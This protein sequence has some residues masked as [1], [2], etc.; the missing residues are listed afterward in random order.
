MERARRIAL[1]RYGVIQ[2]V[3]D[4]GLSTAERGRLVRALAERTY[5]G[6][7]GEPVRVSRNTIDRWKRDYRTGGFDA[8]VPQPPNVHP[9]TPVEVLQ[10]AEALKRENPART[11]RQVQRIL[12][13]TSGWAPSDRTLQRLFERLELNAESPGTGREVFGRFE[14]DRPNELWT[15]DALHGPVIGG[16]KTYLFCFIDDHSRAVMGGR[17]A[18][19]EDVV[20]LAAALR[21]ALAARGV[22]DNIYVDYAETLVM[23]IWRESPRSMAVPG[24]GM[25][26]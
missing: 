3:I 24:L 6:P 16:R 7:F 12:R 11:A 26:A 20:R 17:W 1:F 23:P 8:L 2:E 10:L 5:T 13:T 21:P 9:R 18:F 22:P 19:H 4:P 15:G 25:S 14:A